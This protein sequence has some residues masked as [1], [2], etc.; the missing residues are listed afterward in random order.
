MLDALGLAEDGNRSDHSRIVVEAELPSDR[1]SCIRVDRAEAVEIDAV[2]ESDGLCGLESCMVEVMSP[3]ALGDGDHERRV[4]LENSCHQLEAAS[5]PASSG[6]GVERV[7]G[8]HRRDA[9]R[10]A[11]RVPRMFANSNWVWT[12]SGAALMMASLTARNAPL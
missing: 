8:A 1:R 10:L 4:T 12:M 5:I 2:E 3:G 7:Q 9:R 11:A 6:W